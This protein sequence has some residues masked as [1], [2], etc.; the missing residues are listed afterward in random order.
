M[1]DAGDA[2]AG[3]LGVFTVVNACPGA[4]RDIQLRGRVWNA[5]VRPGLRGGDR[6]V[7]RQDLEGGY[8]V[9]FVDVKQSLEA[10][11]RGDEAVR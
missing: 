4:G 11:L 5:Y 1:E 7:G 8:R 3:K 2:V 10:K 9:Y 6:H